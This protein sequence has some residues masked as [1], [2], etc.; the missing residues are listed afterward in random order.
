MG[1]L[2]AEARSCDW[3]QPLMSQTVSAAGQGELQE[4]LEEWSA[5]GGYLADSSLGLA[6]TLVSPMVLCTCG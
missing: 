5:C 1:S 3:L 6:G 4:G 2:T